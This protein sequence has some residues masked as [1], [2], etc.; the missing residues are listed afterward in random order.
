MTKETELW[1]VSGVVRE[2]GEH[3]D[4]VFERAATR[5]GVEPASVVSSRI[6]KR[7]IDARGRRAPRFQ[8]IVEVEVPTGAVRSGSKGVT[9]AP[10]ARTDEPRSVRPDAA[11]PLVIGLGPCGIFAALRLALAGLRPI[12]LDRGKPVESRAKDVARLMGRGEIDPDSNLCFG[13][14]GA[15]TWSDGKLYTRVGGP[16]LRTVL[17]TIVAHGGPERILVDARPHLGTDRLVKLLKTLRATLADLGAELRFGN[18]VVEIERDAHRHAKGVRLADGQ[19]IAATHI[20]LAPGHSARGLYRALAESGV[21]MTPMPFS[22]GFRV[23]HPQA[24]VNEVQYGRWFE[25]EDLPPAYYELKSRSDKSDVYSFCMCPGGS[26]VPTPTSEGEVC[27]NGMSHAA[28][29]GK[30]ANSAVVVSV[31]P[32]EY[33]SFATS[34]DRASR[35]LA[36]AAFQ[37]ES[38]RVAWELGG[39]KFVAPAQRLVD[40]LDGRPSSEV[41]RTTY[42]RGV[43]PADLSLT[44]PSHVIDVLRAGL[45]GFDERFRGWVTDEAV[46]IGVE[47]RTS[48]PVRI[49]RD[50]TTLQSVNA[51]ALYPAGEGAGYGGGIVSAAIDGIRVAD[52]ILRDVSED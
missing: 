45:A 40:F 27:V 41:R 46:L 19:R 37:A 20:V 49:D 10:A 42:K 11:R 15:G 30:Y 9:P 4:T 51:P 32:G 52:A 24:L 5:C 22:V 23:E 7:S 47:T 8:H 34:D 6:V 26:V 16:H 1:R 50:S 43:T 25:H 3:P 21:A 18:R 33:A 13:E 48:A 12:V 35:L 39:G 36:G 29:S 38:E 31:S 17:E 28:R 44:Y 14:G 2:L